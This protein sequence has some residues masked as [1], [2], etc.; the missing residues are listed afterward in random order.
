MDSF[1]EAFGNPI[2][3]LQLAS[4]RCIPGGALVLGERIAHEINGPTLFNR[5]EVAGAMS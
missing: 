5:T 3:S 2:T 1:G 4:Y